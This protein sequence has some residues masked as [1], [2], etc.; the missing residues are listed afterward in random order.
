M[1]KDVGAKGK[2]VDKFKKA[3]KVLFDRP[4]VNKLV[5]VKRLYS[6]VKIE[7]E[8]IGRVLVDNGTVV[9]K[10]PLS[11]LKLIGKTL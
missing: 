6:H 10:L 4:N 9:N 2:G 7:G 1:A 5:Q 3:V 11:M 8:E